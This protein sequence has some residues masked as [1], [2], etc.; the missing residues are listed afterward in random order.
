[1][2]IS[3]PDENELEFDVKSTDTIHDLKVKFEKEEGIVPSHQS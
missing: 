3:S 1:M 2:R